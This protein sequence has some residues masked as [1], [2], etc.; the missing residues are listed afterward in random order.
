MPEPDLSLVREFK[1]RAEAALPGRI[2]KVVLYGSRARNDARPDSD[3]DVAV[4]VHGKPAAHEQDALSDIGF[5]LLM[6]VGEHIHPIALDTARA[7][8]DS[9]FMETVRRDGRAA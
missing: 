5:D 9:W 3:W 7:E 4:F 8:E 2:A 1:R 6:E